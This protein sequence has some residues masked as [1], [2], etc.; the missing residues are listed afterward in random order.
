MKRTAIGTGGIVV[1]TVIL[2]VIIT[3]FVVWAATTDA[4]SDQVQ[5]LATIST[6]VAA[7]CGLI[8]IIVLIVYTK[9]TFLLRKTAERQLEASE[10][11]VLLFGLSSTDFQSGKPIALLE[12][13]IRNIGSGPAF[14]VVIEPTTSDGV[15]VQFRLPNV[16]C[17]E[18]K[19]Q[20]PATP[21][22]TQDGQTNGMSGSLSLLADLIQRDK[23]SMIVAVKFDSISGK[24]Y[25]SRN[26]VRY[27]PMEKLVS[28][29]LVP[30][31]AEVT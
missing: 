6:L 23:F 24:T 31:I 7:I 1:V 20:I 27:D 2:A 17:I 15:E 28:S 13:T 19:Q 9:E 3:P 11:P 14:N 25:R 21:F 8:G 5:R 29:G 12:P 22:I 26:R 10:K 16:P 18:G 4:T 30:P